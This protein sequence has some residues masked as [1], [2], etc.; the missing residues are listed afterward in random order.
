[1]WIERQTTPEDFKIKYDD[2]ASMAWRGMALCGMVWYGL[3]W[4]YNARIPN[5]SITPFDPHKLYVY[6]YFMVKRNKNE[7]AHFIKFDVS[8]KYEN[9]IHFQLY[10]WNE[11]INEY[12]G[13]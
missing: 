5:K 11:R 3:V 4:L 10:L 6:T 13:T 1:M 12:E 7:N 2:L 8:Q 9:K